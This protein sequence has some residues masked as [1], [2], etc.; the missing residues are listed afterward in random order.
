MSLA[1]EFGQGLIL[2]DQ[3]P[4]DLDYAVL[5][6]VYTTITSMRDISAT[7]DTMGL[8]EEQRNSLNRLPLKT[9]VVKL[10]GRYPKPFLIHIPDVRVDKNISDAE[11]ADYMRDKFTD[12][13]PVASEPVNTVTPDETEN[14]AE[15]QPAE[16]D[17]LNDNELTLLLDVKNR[18]FDPVT[19]HLNS[20]NFTNNL[21]QKL[22]NGLIE[23]G[24][25]EELEIKT[26][27]RGR[28]QKFYKLTDKG[29]AIVGKQNL[30][31]GKGG[32]EHRLH[33]RWLT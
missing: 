1:R 14:K 32:F 9:A 12:L 6:N 15:N 11:V 16:N 20:L 28:P 8:N 3:M 22:Y 18:P 4:S 30:G 13:T 7:A 27:Y 10:A 17:K 21:G 29:I 2:A 19:E 31:S 26:N 24:L 23:K 5:A 25:V 33:Q